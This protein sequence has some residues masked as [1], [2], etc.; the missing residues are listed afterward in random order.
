VRFP[1]PA[2]RA[3][4]GTTRPSSFGAA[5][6]AWSTTGTA[7]GATS[8]TT[9]ST[10][11]ATTTTTTTQPPAGFDPA[12]SAAFLETCQAADFSTGECTCWL[13]GLEAAGMTNDQLAEALTSDEVSDEINTLLTDSLFACIDTTTPDLG[14]TDAFRD[15][16]IADC[17]GGGNLAFCNCSLDAFEAVYPQQELQAIL[18]FEVEPPAG[19]TETA[20]T[21]LGDL[22]YTAPLPPFV[23]PYAC[24][25]DEWGATVTYPSGWA[26]NDTCDGF[27]PDDWDPDVPTPISILV[28]DAFAVSDYADLWG[29]PEEHGL[30]DRTLLVWSWITEDQ[31]E[32]T[33]FVI[34][35]WPDVSG[36]PLMTVSAW[37][38]SGYDYATA[39]LIAEAMIRD[40]D[41]APYAP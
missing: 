13:E 34:P 31:S 8:T 10:T 6:P 25:I 27:A 1:V 3:D 14:F 2:T 20:L 7:T 36:G 11:P 16:F 38:F 39:R 28:D 24:A 37:E 5:H 33:T 12:Q 35:L 32:A 19:F 22:R 17:R 18:D 23:L 15:A 30:A 21:C 4:T 41:I 9:T 26:T 40:M 29:Q